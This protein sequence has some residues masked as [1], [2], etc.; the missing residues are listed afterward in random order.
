MSFQVSVNVHAN[1]GP[2]FSQRCLAI[3]IC[4]NHPL[5]L[6]AARAHRDAQTHVHG[7]MQRQ[8]ALRRPSSK[9]GK[10]GCMGRGAEQHTA[11]IYPLTKPHAG[12]TQPASLGTELNIHPQPMC[13]DQFIL[14]LY[15]AQSAQ[16]ASVIQSANKGM[17]CRGMQSHTYM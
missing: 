3:Y 16:P 14:T 1:I 15:C 17:I 11:W 6:Y 2:R 4:I 7:C 8:A 10:Q 13:S 5:D 12:Q 9:H